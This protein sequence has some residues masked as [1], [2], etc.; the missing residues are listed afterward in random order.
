MFLIDSCQILDNILHDISSRDFPSALF[1]A[2]LLET[3]RHS[4][5][6]RESSA[7]SEN[8]FQHGSGDC[9]WL[10][11]LAP[12]PYSYQR[13]TGDIFLKVHTVFTKPFTSSLGKIRKT[14]LYLFL[15]LPFWAPL[16]WITFYHLERHND[17]YSDRLLYFH[18]WWI[19]EC[20][21]VLV[22]NAWRWIGGCDEGEERK[23]CIS[24]IITCP[25]LERALEYS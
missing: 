9:P 23:Y 3:L 17:T 20:G 11:I 8:V 5:V 13:D 24:S 4:L 7:G 15:G 2:Q 18:W 1:I 14:K 21:Q 6:G 16:K 10:P 25:W 12:F 22:V 19:L